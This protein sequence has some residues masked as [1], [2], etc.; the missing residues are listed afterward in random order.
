MHHIDS[1]SVGS[2]PLPMVLRLTL[3]H[4]YREWNDGSFQVSVPKEIHIYLFFWPHRKFLDMRTAQE[5][6][7][8]K[9]AENCWPFP[10]D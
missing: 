8:P 5:Y 7:S 3:A 6:S 1:A 2:L 4:F 10:L 9:C